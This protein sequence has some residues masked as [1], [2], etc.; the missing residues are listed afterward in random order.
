VWSASQFP[1]FS[2]K[3][4]DL[5]LLFPPFSIPLPRKRETKPISQIVQ[6]PYPIQ[7]PLFL[8]VVSLSPASLADLCRALP[9]GTFALALQ[10]LLSPISSRFKDSLSRSSS[11]R[12][13]PRTSSLLLFLP[14][15]GNSEQSTVFLLGPPHA[16]PLF[17][18]SVP[19]RTD[20][21]DHLRGEIWLP[22][23]TSPSFFQVQLHSPLFC[24]FFVPAPRSDVVEASASEGCCARFDV[25]LPALRC[26]L[27]L[28]SD[29]G[30]RHSL[31]S[32]TSPG[33][34]MVMGV[35]TLR[36]FVP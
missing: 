29:I 16:S 30:R 18:L 27:A 7:F 33:G 5:P 14:T 12:S 11:R 19:L 25:F 34:R 28:P 15:V 10:A 20:R 2:A 1:F 21:E 17:S 3:S 31:P 26:F 8:K 23:T 13:P 6:K 22:R 35:T 24:L 32:L 4:D 36:A 9:S